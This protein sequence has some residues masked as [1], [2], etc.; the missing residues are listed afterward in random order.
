[1]PGNRTAW[2]PCGCLTTGPSADHSVSRLNVHEK[3]PN[4]FTLTRAT[5]ASRS[6]H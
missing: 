6:R 2:V 1:M 5:P 3:G 4:N